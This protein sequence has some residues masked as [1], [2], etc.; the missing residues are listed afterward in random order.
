MLLKSTF[1]IIGLCGHVFV[2]SGIVMPPSIMFISRRAID[3]ELGPQVFH[4]LR[5]IW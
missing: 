1:I 4:H 2:L 3:N 5:S